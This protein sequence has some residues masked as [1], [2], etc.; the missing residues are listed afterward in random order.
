[1]GETTRRTV[2][3]EDRRAVAQQIG[4]I[5]L[6]G[7][8][9]V[10]LS[11]WQAQV[12]PAENSEV[13]FDHYREVQEDMLELRSD[14]IDAAE[15]GT[16]RSTTVELGTRYPTRIFF[17]NG[18]PPQGSI[19]TET[20]SNGTITADG[21]EVPRVCGLNGTVE[22]RS[23]VL[24]A[25]YN[26]LAESKTPPCRYENTV[27]YRQASDGGALFESNQTLT[28]LQVTSVLCPPRELDEPPWR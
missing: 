20:L 24:N 16:A 1:M 19:Q 13:E 2:L 27:L 28:R 23:L 10:A 22:T 11:I 12:V 8:A 17:V 3:S 26:Q 4:F 15:T 6:F 14:F 7:I 5:L 9:V 21:F 18:P 25:D